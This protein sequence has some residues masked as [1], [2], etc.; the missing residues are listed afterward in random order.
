MSLPILFHGDVGGTKDAYSHDL[1]MESL[2]GSPSSNII[3]RRL[4]CGRLG[5][6]AGDDGGCMSCRLPLGGEVGSATARNLMRVGECADVLRLMG[7]E[8]DEV[9]TLAGRA[10]GGKGSLSK[11]VSRACGP[12]PIERMLS[13]L[14]GT[15]QIARR[16]TW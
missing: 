12:P 15:A 16:R 13:G 9:S 14:E 11:K 7:G 5:G 6:Q 2:F 10:G 8:R 4:L 3:W 1:G